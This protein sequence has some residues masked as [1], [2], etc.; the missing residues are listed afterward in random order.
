MAIKVD[1]E[2]AHDGREWDL[3]KMCNGFGFCDQWIN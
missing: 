2:K 3:L 1:I